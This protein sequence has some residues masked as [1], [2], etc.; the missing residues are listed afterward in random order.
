VLA[1][2]VVAQMTP[3]R[4]TQVWSESAGAQAAAQ[5]LKGLKPLL[6]ERF[7]QYLPG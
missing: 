2:A 5:A 1:V 4:D 3:L 6:P 7:G